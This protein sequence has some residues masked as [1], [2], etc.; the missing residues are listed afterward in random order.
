MCSQRTGEPTR[1]V[2]GCICY[3][4]L[5]LPFRIYG[6]VCNRVDR[7]WTS[8]VCC[9][10]LNSHTHASWSIEAERQRNRT[11]HHTMSDIAQKCRPS[12]TCTLSNA[13]LFVL[14]SIRRIMIAEC[15][16]FLSR[17]GLCHSSTIAAL[18]TEAPRQHNLIRILL[19]D[20]KWLN[21]EVNWF[22]LKYRP[23]HQK[24]TPTKR[25]RTYR[26]IIVIISINFWLFTLEST[27]I[28]NLPCGCDW[29]EPFVSQSAQITI[30][31]DFPFTLFILFI[32]F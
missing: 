14:I 6:V 31:P 4:V 10:S 19:A 7:Q 11:E 3:F 5:T 2:C 9:I 24:P 12:I 22:R 18:H 23:P 27:A 13:P 1:R 8:Y 29:V 17:Y 21:G 25:T 28:E 16:C 15:R 32:F 20:G 30:D 26:I